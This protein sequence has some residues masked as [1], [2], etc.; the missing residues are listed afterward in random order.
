VTASVFNLSRKDAVI[1]ISKGIVFVD[2]VA[3][4]KPDYQLKDNQKL[5]LRG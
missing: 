2:G 5:V 3:M 4:D 1:A